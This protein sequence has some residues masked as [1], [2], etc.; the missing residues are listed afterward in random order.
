MATPCQTVVVRYTGWLTDETLFDSSLDRAVPFEFVFGL[1]HV[2]P[3]WDEG[4][5]T[6]KEGSKRRLIIPPDLAY[7][8]AGVP[9]VIPPSATLIF[10]VELL[11]IR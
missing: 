10:D 5:A 11:A 8:E 9:P 7:G 3:G 4:L 2:I 6:M 1:G